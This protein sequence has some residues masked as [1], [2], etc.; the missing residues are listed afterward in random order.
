MAVLCSAPLGGQRRQAG[1]FRVGAIAIVAL[2]ATT[3]AACGDDSSSNNG[4]GD[5]RGPFEVKVVQAD[6]PTRQR[7]GETVL[8]RLGVRNTGQE[9]V[10]A[11]TTTVAIAGEEGEGSSLP[12]GIRSPE[13]G[14]AQ[15]DRPVWVLSE[16]YPRISGSTESAGAENASR[17]TFDF[18]PLESGETVKA[19]WKLTASRTGSYRLFYEIGAGLSGETKAE[20]ASGVEAGGSFTVR[21]TE[22]TPETI[23]TDSGEVVEIKRGEETQANR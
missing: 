16:K 3:F 7:L 4:S 12:F 15:P 18:G 22:A 13:P 20:T 17:K 1:R 8:L 6:F 2:A 19:V 23:V 10:P 11:L 9:T 14:L 21:I 5:A